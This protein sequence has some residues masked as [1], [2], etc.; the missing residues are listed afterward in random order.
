M[1]RYVFPAL[2]EIVIVGIFFAAGLVL[3]AMLT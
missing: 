3:V 1:R 2:S